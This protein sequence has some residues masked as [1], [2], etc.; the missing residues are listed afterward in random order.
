MTLLDNIALPLRKWTDL[1]EASI[2]SVAR[3][4]LRLVSLDGFENHLPAQISGGM[5]KRVAIAQAL[6]GEPEVV[7]L[8]EPTAGLDP[9]HDR[10]PGAPLSLRASAA[11]RNVE[12]CA[13]RQRDLSVNR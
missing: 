4:R 12:S 6:L 3:A 2:A 13:P 8:D 10:G 5:R 1:D 11:D 9:E 7:L